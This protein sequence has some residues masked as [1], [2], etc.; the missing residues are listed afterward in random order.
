[1]TSRP[2]HRSRLFWLGVLG[3]V[4][5][6]GAWGMSNF[7]GTQATMA[8]RHLV[9]SEKGRLLWHHS[10]TNNPIRFLFTSEGADLFLSTSQWAI[11]SSE[12]LPED[13][14]WLPLPQI[15]RMAALDQRFVILPYWLLTTS[16]LAIWLLSLTG[17]QRRKARRLKN[18]GDLALQYPTNQGLSH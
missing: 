3:L 18:L 17:W 11:D 2:W 6:I 12:V 7:H 5:L 1:M 14:R 13:R 16:Y 9:I 10:P 4:L 8:G 15:E